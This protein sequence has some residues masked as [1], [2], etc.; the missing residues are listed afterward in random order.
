VLG[1]AIA[2]DDR[3]L[4]GARALTTAP[5]IERSRPAAARFVNVSR[6]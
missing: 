6:V 3:W 2:P 4:A 5:P 1:G